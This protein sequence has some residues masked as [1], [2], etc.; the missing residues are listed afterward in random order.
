MI[1]HEKIA[2]CEALKQL[3]L[4]VTSFTVGILGMSTDEATWKKT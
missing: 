4:S 2:P 1:Q 3:T